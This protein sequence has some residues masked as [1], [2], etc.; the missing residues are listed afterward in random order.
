MNL[1]P[2]EITGILKEQIKNYRSKLSLEDV[3]TVVTVGD[4][5]SKIHGLEKCMA[6]ELLEFEGGVMGMALNLEQEFVGAVLLGDDSDIKE[7]SQVKRTGKIVSVP[8][9]EALLGRVV[10]ALGEPID[11]KG[12]IF[13][14]E[15][16]PIE[17]P[18]YGIITRKS[19]C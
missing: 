11:G 10:N 4:G 14:S 17:S 13:T 2:D 7:G 6:G 18:A 16:R 8:V 15:T 19:V 12:E 9:G 5:I 3:G 1:R